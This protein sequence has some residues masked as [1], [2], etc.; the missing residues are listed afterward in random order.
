MITFMFCF[1]NKQF[2]PWIC[3][4]YYWSLSCNVH[5]QKNEISDHINQTNQSCRVLT[6]NTCLEDNEIIG[7]RYT[8]PFPLLGGKKIFESMQHYKLQPLDY[9]STIKHSSHGATSYLESLVPMQAF[10]VLIAAWT[11]LKCYPSICWLHWQHRCLAINQSEEKEQKTWK[12]AVLQPI[13]M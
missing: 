7:Q 2:R 9:N 13:R 1:L 6:G 11:L 10:W 5:P 8:L 12:W 3:S 4:K